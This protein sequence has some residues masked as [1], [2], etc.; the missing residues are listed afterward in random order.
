M[1]GGSKPKIRGNLLKKWNINWEVTVNGNFSVIHDLCHVIKEI[2]NLAGDNFEES[3]VIM[4]EALKRLTFAQKLISIPSFLL[5]HLTATLGDVCSGKPPYYRMDVRLTWM[6]TYLGNMAASL[7]WFVGPA[8]SLVS[9]DVENSSWTPEC[10]PTLYCIQ[11]SRKSFTILHILA[12]ER[13]GWP[14]R[15]QA[16]PMYMQNQGRLATPFWRP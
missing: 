7:P 10:R 5:H 2:T 8:W 15:D 6:R 4:L 1:E 13:P 14:V 3:K 16:G 9:Q 11:T 12:R